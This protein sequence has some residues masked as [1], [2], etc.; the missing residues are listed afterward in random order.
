MPRKQRRQLR[1][2]PRVIVLVIILQQM[3]L[4]LELRR[5][6]ELGL[7]LGMRRLGLRRL[8]LRLRRRLGLRLRRR[9]GLMR[10]E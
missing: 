8:R 1:G 5:R 3:R 9:L 2:E 6:P 7:E 4:G 10:R